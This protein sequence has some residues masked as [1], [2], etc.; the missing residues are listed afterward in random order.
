MLKLCVKKTINI[1]SRYLFLIIIFF[2]GT[3]TRL[4][5]EPTG[6]GLRRANPSAR[7][8]FM[9]VETPAHARHTAL[10]REVEVQV[11]LVHNVPPAARAGRGHMETNGLRMVTVRAPRTD[12]HE[13]RRV[14]LFSSPTECRL[15]NVDVTR[16]KISTSANRHQSQLGSRVCV[17]SYRFVYALV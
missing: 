13:P 9:N 14:Y 10:S 3:E 8:L 12:S 7:I 17:Y 6:S 16:T 11:S 2:F 4:R 15:S 1:D 5:S